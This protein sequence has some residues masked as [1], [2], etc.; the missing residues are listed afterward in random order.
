MNR[1]WK[2]SKGWAVIGYSKYRSRCTCVWTSGQR[3]SNSPTINW[4][5]MH[6]VLHGNLGKWKICMTSVPHSLMDEQKQRHLHC[7]T[8]EISYSPWSLDLTL[9][10][11]FLLGKVKNNLKRKIQDVEGINNNVTVRI[12]WS[13]FACL[14]WQLCANIRNIQKVCCSRDRLLWREIK[15]LFFS[16]FMHI[17][18]SRSR[19]EILLFDHIWY[20]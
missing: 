11:L 16:Y 4:E 8:R 13:L 3:L 10:E 19:P 20:T 12:K 15:Q 17:C 5:M 2:W 14:Q 6:Q 9:P 18:P 1:S 7:S